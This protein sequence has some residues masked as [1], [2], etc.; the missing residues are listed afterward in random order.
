VSRWDTDYV[1]L[2]TK[3]IPHPL[4][5]SDAPNVRRTKGLFE[6]S[7]P[8]DVASSEGWGT[9]DIAAILPTGAAARSAEHAHDYRVVFVAHKIHERRKAHEAAWTEA[10]RSWEHEWKRF[11]LI[12]DA[13]KLLED[14]TTTRELDVVKL[15]LRSR[16]RPLADAGSLSCDTLRRSSWAVL[17]G[18]A[19]TQA[20]YIITGVTVV[21]PVLATVVSAVSL[22]FYMMSRMMRREMEDVLRSSGSS[23]P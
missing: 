13:E 5:W 21:H 1:P 10:I 15:G 6:S 19:L 3:V 11:L 12:S 23:G 4:T 7:G 18:V 16:G 20:V 14:W 22:S 8:E 2:A 9:W 17:L